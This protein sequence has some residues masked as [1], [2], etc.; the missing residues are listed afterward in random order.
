MSV[1]QLSMPVEHEI[2]EVP[3]TGDAVEWSCYLPEE[4]TGWFVA[5][6]TAS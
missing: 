3:K 6:A 2:R 5:A 4:G 1:S